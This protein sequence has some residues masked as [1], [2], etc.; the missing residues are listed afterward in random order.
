MPVKS[1]CRSV[2][3][4]A[5]VDL[6][7]V[8]LPRGARVLLSLGDHSSGG[9]PPRCASMLYG[10]IIYLNIDTYTARDVAFMIMLRPA[11]TDQ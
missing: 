1:R 6:P 9:S 10:N 2:F 11:I 8:D 4:Q 7:R 3:I 5:R